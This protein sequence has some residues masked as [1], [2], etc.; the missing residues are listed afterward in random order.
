[1]LGD[2]VDESSMN[3]G[4]GLFKVLPPQIVHQPPNCPHFTIYVVIIK[5]KPHVIK[6]ACDVALNLTL[7][8]LKPDKNR[9]K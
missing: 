3:R 9:L 7:V 2:M 1:M 5:L 8:G 4:P 6:G